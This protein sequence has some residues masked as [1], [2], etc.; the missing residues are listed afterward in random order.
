M[1]VTLVQLRHLI[2]L[3]ESGSFSKAATAVHLT[4][5]ALSRSI[6]SLEDELGQPLADRVGKRVEFTPVGREVLDRARQLVADARD[7]EL[8]GRWLAEGRTGVLR[9]GLGSGPGVMLMTP[10]LLEVAA[11][12]PQW[13]VEVARGATELLVQRLRARQLDAL[14]VD[15]RSLAPASDLEVEQVREM[16]GAFMVRKGHPLAGKRRPRFDDVR[17]YPLASSPLSDEVARVLVQRY[18]PLAHPD[19]AVSVRCDEIASLIDVTEHSD[20]VLLAIRASAPQLVE[21]TLDPPLDATAR[22][23]LV[24]LARRTE[25]QALEALRSLMDE[26]LR[27]AA[28]RQKRV[29]RRAR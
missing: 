18:G 21:L 14:V 5:P 29:V 24:K 27:D 22:L 17:A 3:A 7:L 15:L 2:A 6:K 13:K 23:G 12:R 25:P 28:P 11:R 9:V 20:A 26:R 4:Q 1:R 16:R 8:R 19:V 10:L